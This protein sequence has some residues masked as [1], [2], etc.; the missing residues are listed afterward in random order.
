MNKHTLLYIHTYIYFFFKKS[1]QISW[2]FQSSNHYILVPF[3]CSF[4]SYMTMLWFGWSSCDHLHCSLD[5]YNLSILDGSKVCWKSLT[6]YCTGC[7]IRINN[8]SIT[9]EWRRVLFHFN[10][11]HSSM[12]HR[13]LF[14]GIPKINIIKSSPL[15]F[16][17]I[18]W[19]NY[20]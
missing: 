8:L 18:I 9:W 7:L 15:I 1:K 19:Y 12:F 14:H 17:S 5:K 13:R 4:L 20:F 3:F 10:S 11:F 2:G 16:I 6:S